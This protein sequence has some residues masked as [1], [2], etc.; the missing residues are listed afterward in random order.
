METEEVL[1]DYAQIS[2]IGT[3]LQVVSNMK[4]PS[5]RIYSAFLLTTVFPP[6]KEFNLKTGF[7]M[8]NFILRTTFCKRKCRQRIYQFVYFTIEACRIEIADRD[9]PQIRFEIHDILLRISPSRA[10]SRFFRSY[11]MLKF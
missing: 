6:L 10:I 3:F 2:N 7:H 9:S 1:M 8:A 5:S 4:L 11:K